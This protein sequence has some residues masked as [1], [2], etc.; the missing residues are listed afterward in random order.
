MD[1]YGP[2]LDALRR[3]TVQAGRPPDAVTP[4]VVV[5]VHV[6]DDREQ[7]GRAHQRGSQWLSELYGLPT[8]AFHRHLVAGQADACAA[9]LHRFAQAGARHIIVMVAGTGA[10]GHFT[11]LRAAFVATTST[12]GAVPVGAT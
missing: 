6:G 12:S 5:F 2:A 4:G 10:L 11:A 8:K 7:A 1:E 9:Q 3:E